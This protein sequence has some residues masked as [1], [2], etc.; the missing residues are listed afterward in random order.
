MAGLT[1]VADEQDEIE[2]SAELERSADSD[3]DVD[4]ADDA[5]DP[6]CTVHVSCVPRGATLS[7]VQHVF[8]DLGSV[9][10]YRVSDSV[11]ALELESPSAVMAAIVKSG[12]VLTPPKVGLINIPGDAIVVSQV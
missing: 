5:A 11:V 12:T 8:A 9:F 4:V 6:S 10:C 1:E 7:D 2:P 3:G